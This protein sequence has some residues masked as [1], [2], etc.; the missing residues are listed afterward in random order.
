MQRNGEKKLLAELLFINLQRPHKS[1]RSCAVTQYPLL[2]SIQGCQKYYRAHLDTAGILSAQAVIAQSYLPCSLCE[3]CLRGRW[4]RQWRGWCRGAGGCWSS[5]FGWSGSVR[6]SGCRWTGKS[7]RGTDQSR[8]SAATQTCPVGDRERERGGWRRR[9]Q[10]QTGVS[11]F[12][13]EPCVSSCRFNLHLVERH[14]HREA[15][16]VVAGA[17]G[18]FRVGLQH[19]ASTVRPRPTS[20]R[21]VPEHTGVVVFVCL[22]NKKSY[23]DHHRND[24][25]MQWKILIN[26]E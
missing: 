5:G 21:G 13:S 20:L 19:T 16:Q 26:D 7:M 18:V 1:F 11:T 15:A 22:W 10:K 6:T 3:R 17:H 23:N 25:F 4:G 8:W 14:E 12:M 2:C 24:I 9:K